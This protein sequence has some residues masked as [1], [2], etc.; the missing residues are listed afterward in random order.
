MNS[1][2]ISIIIPAYNLQNYIGRCLDS[3]LAQSFKDF[4][5][6]IINDG[7]DDATGEICDSYSRK[8]NR[9]KLINQKN[10]GLGCARNKGLDNAK[11]EL[12]AFVDG[13][14]VLHP[15]YLETLYFL[16]IESDADI[17]VCN[18][19]KGCD[20]SLLFMKNYHVQK[21]DI[22]VIDKKSLLKKMYNEHPFITVW[23]KIYRRSMIKSGMVAR[24]IGEDVEFNSRMYFVANKVVYVDYPL[25]LWVTRKRSLSNASFN[26]TDLNKI[27]NYFY[28]WVNLR[29]NK[30][31][32]N[33]A[34]KKLYKT[35]LSVRYDA[36]K[37]F[38]NSVKHSISYYTKGSLRYLYRDTSIIQAF[39]YHFLVHSPSIYKAMRRA[40]EGL[41]RLRRR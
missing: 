9:I 2:I 16:A 11:G 30:F 14:D 38:T 6:I 28:A 15:Q 24:G 34:I 12:I 8:D 25:Y 40:I 17:V 5:A 29:E 41:T 35:F 20:E 18:Y 7:S 26:D 21:N 1:P 31:Y 10:R 23:A 4:E 19:M 39:F 37:N 27:K 36:P 3:V 33:Y 22:K 13:D 32:S